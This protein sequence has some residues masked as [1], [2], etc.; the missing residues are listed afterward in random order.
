MLV[1]NILPNRRINN[2]N[3]H[4][5][6]WYIITYVDCSL[7]VY[8]IQIQ[9][10]SPTHAIDELNEYIMFCLSRL[11]AFVLSAE[12][13]CSS[14][15]DLFTSIRSDMWSFP[16]ASNTISEN[17]HASSHVFLFSS[18]LKLQL[19]CHPKIVI[20]IYWVAETRRTSRFGGSLILNEHD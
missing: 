2:N 14:L 12:I 4:L 11:H 18:G 3:N 16:Y 5:C 9:I 8:F 17:K 20:H 1:S 13:H 7:H 10:T 6:S 15:I 19:K